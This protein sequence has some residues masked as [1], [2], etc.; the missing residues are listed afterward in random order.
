M[1]KRAEVGTGLHQGT[2]GHD[3][4]LQ[5]GI[6]TTPPSPSMLTAHTV[7]GPQWVVWCPPCDHGHEHGQITGHRS[8]HCLTNARQKDCGGGYYLIPAGK[9]LPPGAKILDSLDRRRIHR[10]TEML[11]AKWTDP[12]PMPGWRKPIEDRDVILTLIDAWV[13]GVCGM[14]RDDFEKETKVW[15]QHLPYPS[16]EAQQ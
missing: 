3:A 6:G 7:R 2:Y 11:N 1:K 4:E 5:N 9:P 10:L 12:Q 14:R 8:P 16:K 15:E 13:W